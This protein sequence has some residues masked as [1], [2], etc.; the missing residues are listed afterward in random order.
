MMYLPSPQPW[1]SSPVCFSRAANTNLET[2]SNSD[3]LLRDALSQS[4][5]EPEHTHTQNRQLHSSKPLAGKGTQ[6]LWSLQTFTDGVVL[7]VDPQAVGGLF[8]RTQRQVR[9]DAQVG[10]QRALQRLLFLVARQRRLQQGADAGVWK[11]SRAEETVF[12]S[13]RETPK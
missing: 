3:S 10:T 2:V 8:G 12:S 5:P 6:S 4:A 1:P 7:H 11:E 13:N 9:Q